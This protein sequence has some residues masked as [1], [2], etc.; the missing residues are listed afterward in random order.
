M[1][2]EKITAYAQIDER[3]LMDVYAESSH[4]SV[5][6]FFPHSSDREAS[7]K[8][9]EAEFLEFLKTDFFSSQ[10]NSYYVLTTNDCWLA[11]LRVSTVHKRQFLLEA[12]ETHLKYRR[13]G[14]ATRLIEAVI[15]DLKRGGSFSLHVSIHKD[16]RASLNL[17][18]KLG[19]SI[20]ADSPGHEEN[21]HR[22]HL[23]FVYVED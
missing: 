20:I 14:F 10:Q 19:F 17:H 21:R 11:T 18:A 4:Q 15:D 16:N 23:A 6:Y 13:K 3:L 5:E 9:I 2:I 1:R 7:Q 8:L 22:Q 12:L